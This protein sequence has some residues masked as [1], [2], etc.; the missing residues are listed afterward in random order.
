MKKVSVILIDWQVRESFHSVDYLNRQTVPRSEYE[1]IWV[2]F[3]DH[4]PPQLRERW[5]RGLVD[6]WIVLEKPGFY[7]KHLLFNEGVLASQ[8]E[9]IAVCDSDALFS[10]RF[11]ESIIKT[12]D[13]SGD[14]NIV[15]YLDE[16][17]NNNRCFY[18][19][20]DVSWDKAMATPG[21][22]NWSEKYGKPYG[23]TTSHDIVHHRNYGA[24]FCARLEDVIKMGGFD[25][26]PSYHCFF[27]GPYELGW[28]M[29][30]RGF[31][32]IWHDS[33]WLLHVWHPWVRDGVD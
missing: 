25:E 20:R 7:F 29:V 16:V 18:P 31:K 2:E 26:H 19:F 32:E 30:N 28:R 4:R 13:D 24:C 11:I 12:F 3:Y 9:I 5:E 15:L 10:P 27:C 6:K 17:R 23:L 8:G 21:L 1:V 22:I 14:E 33:E